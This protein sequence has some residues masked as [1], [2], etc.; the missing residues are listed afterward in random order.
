[1]YIK[2]EETY[3][4]T[5]LFQL[6]T[7]QF[8]DIS[9]FSARRLKRGNFFFL[10]SLTNILTAVALI[11]KTIKNITYQTKRTEPWLCWSL[12]L[13]TGICN[14]VKTVCLN[15]Y[16]PWNWSTTFILIS[17]FRNWKV[18]KWDYWKTESKSNERSLKLIQ[19]LKSWE[20][21]LSERSPDLLSWAEKQV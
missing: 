10:Q 16:F 3:E 21:S 17:N 20:G 13:C 12:H 4:I 1:M 14:F 18:W 15:F 2:P 19:M 6:I 5:L 8:Q 7:R 9:N 11:M